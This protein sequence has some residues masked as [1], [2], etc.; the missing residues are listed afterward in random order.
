MIYLDT[1]VV[2]WLYAGLI[3]RVSQKARD[4]ISAQDL[5]ISPMVSLELAYLQETGRIAGCQ[6]EQ[7]E[8]RLGYRG[9]SVVVH[10]D[11]L[12]LID[13]DG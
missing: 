11:E 2:V 10:R 5:A 9:R 7:I 13:S 3:E 6:S 1:H 4:L 8:E 12:V